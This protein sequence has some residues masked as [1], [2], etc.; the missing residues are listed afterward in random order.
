MTPYGSKTIKKPTR[1]L[2]AK[3]SFNASINDRDKASFHRQSGGRCCCFMIKTLG[4]TCLQAL[5]TLSPQK[6]DKNRNFEHFGHFYE[7]RALPT[8]LQALLTFSLSKNR[9]KTEILSILAILFTKTV[10]YQ[11][12][13][14]LREKNGITRLHREITWAGQQICRFSTKNIHGRIKSVFLK[15]ILDKPFSTQNS[16]KLPRYLVLIS[17]G[18]FCE[19]S[20][21]NGL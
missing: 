13:P 11:L 9:L 3:T 2:S 18:S 21:L 1:R 19:F 20:V 5:L 6:T 12:L 15:K 10:H 7:N 16:Q 17:W 14:I 4:G 8:C